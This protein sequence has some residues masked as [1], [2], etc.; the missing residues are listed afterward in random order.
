MKILCS[1]LLKSPQYPE[2]S[3]FQT[4]EAR[5]VSTVHKFGLEKHA[6][7]KH[8]DVRSTGDSFALIIYGKLRLLLILKLR[9]CSSG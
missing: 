8:P 1:K 5:R 6:L 9:G 4:L 3:L 7:S 2:Q